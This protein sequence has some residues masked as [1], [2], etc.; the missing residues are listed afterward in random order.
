MK[1]T[2]PG[3]KG[4]PFFGVSHKINKRTVLRYFKELND[5]YGDLIKIPGVHGDA[6]IVVHPEDLSQ[7]FRGEG[8]PKLFKKAPLYDKLKP[9]LGDSL[10]TTEGEPWKRQRQL[11]QPQFHPKNLTSMIQ[12]ISDSADKMVWKWKMRSI[13]QQTFD[14]HEDFMHFTMDVVTRTLLG[15]DL[16][17]SQM[18]T[19]DHCFRV[20]QDFVSD[21]YWDIFPLPL[22]VP[23]RRNRMLKSAVKE[24][25]ELFYGMI[26][27]RRRSGEQREDLLAKLMQAADDKGHMSERQLRDEVV[28]MF[29]AGHETTA[30]ALSWSIYFYTQ[31]RERRALLDQE[32]QAVLGDGKFLPEHIGRLNYTKM[33]IKESMRLY[34]PVYFATRTPIEDV[35]LHGYHVPKNSLLLIPMWLVHRHPEFWPAPDC[36]MPERFSADQA[37]SRNPFAYIPFLAGPHRCIGEHLAVMESQIALAKALQ[38]F[39]VHLVPDQRIEPEALITLRPRF[40]IQVRL[41]PRNHL[42]NTLTDGPSRNVETALVQTAVQ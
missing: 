32:I 18:Q 17:S 26:A 34:P 37:T 13:S 11:A 31:E 30:I 1:H 6:Y 12:I 9:I 22:S 5:T 35:K 16:D 23:T 21:S 42:E 36:F 40:G 39:E 29:L 41:T 2:V 7:I 14:V 38:I 8:E 10:L 3:P 4:V 24:L 19:L 15:S 28:T 33:F 25:D 27:E 20:V